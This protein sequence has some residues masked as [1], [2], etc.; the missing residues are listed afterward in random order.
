MVGLQV[1]LVGLV[2]GINLEYA[3]LAAVGGCLHGEEAHHTGLT[4]HAEAVNLVG[5]GQ[6]LLQVLRIDLYL[7]YTD[8]ERLGE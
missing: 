6:V 7:G 2:G 4:L 3:D 5:I 8:D 1:A